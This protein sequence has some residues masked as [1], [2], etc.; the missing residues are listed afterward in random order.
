[1]YKVAENMGIEVLDT[2]GSFREKHEDVFLSQD[3]IC[4]FN[5]YGHFIV[6]KTIAEYL[7]RNPGNDIKN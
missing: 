3:D 2:L 1:M 7:E 6:A 4:H 5:D